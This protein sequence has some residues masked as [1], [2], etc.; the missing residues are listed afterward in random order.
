MED[1]HKEF[2]QEGYLNGAKQERERILRLI[3]KLTET[4]NYL[5]KD[6]LIKGI[7]G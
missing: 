3:D 1:L 6:E 5:D 4:Y 7:T 2:M